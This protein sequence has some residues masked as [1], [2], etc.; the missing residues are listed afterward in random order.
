V[1]RWVKLAVWGLVSIGV[2][3]TL[4]ECG[5]STSGALLVTFA[6]AII[7]VGRILY[8]TILASRFGPKTVAGFLRL[9]YLRDIFSVALLFLCF[10]ISLVIGPEEAKVILGGGVIG[11]VLLAAPKYLHAIPRLQQLPG[12]TS[13]PGYSPPASLRSRVLTASIPLCLAV[14]CTLVLWLVGVLGNSAAVVIVVTSFTMLVVL[15]PRVV[16]SE[17]RRM[18]QDSS[19]NGPIAQSRDGHP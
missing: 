9:V 16:L 2:F 17:A 7:V 3:P 10:L 12:E 4:R 11:F 13:L 5:V 8:G 1:K 15:I 14:L 19:R 6:Y 18:Q